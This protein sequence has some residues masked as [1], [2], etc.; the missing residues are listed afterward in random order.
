MD[1]GYHHQSIDHIM[2][3]AANAYGPNEQ[4]K[5]FISNAHGSSQSGS[6]NTN[7]GPSSS[8]L[9]PHAGLLASVAVPGA[10]HSSGIPIQ[11]QNHSKSGSIITG[12]PLRPPP[13]TGSF[14]VTTPASHVSKIR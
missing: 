5:Y 10:S 14:H 3:K 11:Q 7:S 8:S 6:S 1:T 4:E 12:N 9:R 2:S 13:S